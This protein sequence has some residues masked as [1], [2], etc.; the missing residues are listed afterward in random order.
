MI[1]TTRSTL[2]TLLLAVTPSA[3][4]F[5]EDAAHDWLMK[6]GQAARDLSYDGY[7]VYQHGSQL[8]AMRI[9][10]QSRDGR[11]RE[12]LTSL[13]G[14]PREII[15]NNE[16]VSCY[17]PDENSVVVTHRKKQEK[18][19]PDILPINL[20]RLDDNYKIVTRRGT[21]VSNRQTQVV[22][23]RPR[24]SYRYGY[25]LWA[26][27][28][29]GLLLKADL[30]DNKGKPLEQFMFTDVQINKRVTD[31][32]FRPSFGSSKM[33]WHRGKKSVTDVS[34]VPELKIVKLPPG[35]SLS[36]N[37]SNVTPVKGKPM[38]H[39][40]YSDGLA[41]VS[42]FVEKS[43]SATPVLTQG[44]NRMGAVNA[45]RSVVT[46]YQVTVVGEVPA[47]T[48]KMIG[49]SVVLAQ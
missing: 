9:I 11:V 6:M 18:S 5:A 22:I 4:V 20:K 17:L 2:L 1:N 31:A 33:K 16:L 49:S 43:A 28:Q 48:V 26:D 39:L 46:G 30:V 29:S 40:V 32:D 41:A 47:E 21:R 37:M 8:E 38:N 13:N 34:N 45:Y 44:A 35:F 7:F 27:M 25:R 15:R 24:D 3:S 36:A 23:I 42:I 10:H 14:S 12:R 19:F